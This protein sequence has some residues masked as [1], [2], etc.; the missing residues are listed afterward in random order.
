MRWIER[1]TERI[2]VVVAALLAGCGGAGV[3]PRLALS[4][5]LSRELA[6][7]PGESAPSWAWSAGGGLE[8]S[9]D[10]GLLAS[11]RGAGRR[12]LDVPVP[13]GPLASRCEGSRHCAWE[14]AARA[15]AW[16]RWRRALRPV[17]GR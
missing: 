4:A 17:G 11:S 12:P 1:S 7:G 3:V 15:S 6:S 16:R 8:W 14:A 13:E 5:A 10:Q 2:G 9:T